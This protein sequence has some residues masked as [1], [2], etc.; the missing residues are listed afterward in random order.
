MVG[1][2]RKDNSKRLLEK[3]FVLDLDYKVLLLPKEEQ[4]TKEVIIFNTLNELYIKYGFCS[5]T[6]IDAIKNKTIHG[7]FLWDYN[8]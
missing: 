6:I 2:T 5:T 8:N 7:G 4:N 3:Y 1:F